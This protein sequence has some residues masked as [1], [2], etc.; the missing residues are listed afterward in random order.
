MAT[1]TRRGYDPAAA[2]TGNGPTNIEDEGLFQFVALRQKATQRKMMPKPAAG[3]PDVLASN[4]HARTAQRKSKLIKLRARDTPEMSAD[5]IIVVLKPRETLHLNMAFQTGDV[6]AAIAQYVRGEAAATLNVWPV[7]TQNLIVCGT[8]HV[9]AT[10]KLAP[11]W[12]LNIGSG[13]DPLRRH[14]KLNRDVCRGVVTVRADETTASLKGE[15][16]WREGE[17]A[18]VR[19]LG[20]CNAVVLTFVDQRVIRYV[21]YNCECTVVREYKKTVPACYRCETLGHWID[22]YPH[23]DVARCGCCGQKVGASEQ[24]LA[25]HENKTS[26]A[27]GNRVASSG[28]SG[29]ATGPAPENKT[30]KKNKNRNASGQNVKTPFSHEGDFSPLENSNVATTSKVSTS[31]GVASFSPSSLELELK[32]EISFLQTKN[33]QLEQKYI[34]LQNIWAEPPLPGTLDSGGKSASL[35]SGMGPVTYGPLIKNLESLMTALEKLS[36][37]TWHR[38]QQ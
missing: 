35:C 14:V 21:H 37:T 7:C 33:E 25:E 10:N 36:P 28:K 31:V 3:N 18:F 27:S 8:Q 29:Q 4:G 22:N 2:A 38:C 12:N 32:K 26:K 34:A 16:V 30:S 5:D 24:G 11:D 6:G 1:A 13:S 9:E 15:V 23:P 20:T 19:K 17:L